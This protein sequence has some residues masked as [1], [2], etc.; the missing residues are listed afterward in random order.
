MV[1]I[2]YVDYTWIRVTITVL[3]VLILV[4]VVVAVILW[5]SVLVME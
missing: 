3:I 1:R 4:L 2:E 5:S